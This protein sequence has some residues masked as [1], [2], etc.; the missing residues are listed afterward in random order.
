[1][2]L[3]LV[4]QFITTIV[5]ASHG[6]ARYGQTSA[7]FTTCA[8]N[9]SYT[10]VPG[11]NCGRIA[12][13]HNVPMAALVSLNDLRP[14]CADLRVGE[15]LCLPQSCQLYPVYL[16]DTCKHISEANHIALSQLLEWNTHVNSECTNLFPGDQVCIAEPQMLPTT[17][18]PVT[19]TVIQPRDYATTTVAPPGHTPR[20]TTRKCGQY[21]QMK[22]GDFCQ[23][24]ADNFSIDL[25]LFRAINPAINP[26]CTNLVPGLYYCVSPTQDWNQ[27]TTTTTVSTYT[28]APAPTTSGT[29]PRC[30]E[31]RPEMFPFCDMLTAC[32]VVRRSIRR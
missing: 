3:T 15:V 25:D 7:N 28:S 16:G 30:Y 32:I 19:A 31:V 21:Y 9:M 27:T 17:T 2:S 5:F 12:R 10:V 22:D 26:E 20:G 29:T 23:L 11:D 8:S 1:M 6:S 18:T 24:I 14:D 13:A 4:L